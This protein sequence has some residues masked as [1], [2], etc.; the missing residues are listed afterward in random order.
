MAK[1]QQVCKRGAMAGCLWTVSCLSLDWPSRWTTKRIILH[2]SSPDMNYKGYLCSATCFF[3][4]FY[5]SLKSFFGALMPLVRYSVLLAA[6]LCG[7]PS[8]LSVCWQHRDFVYEMKW[9]VAS[10]LDPQITS[11]RQTTHS[12]F[13]LLGL[14]HLLSTSS[15][16]PQSALNPAGVTES[17]K[18]TA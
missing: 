4:T 11:E 15:G 16:H 10:L 14:L 12:A 18:K 9:E 17:N 2:S 13:L 3:Y 6:C 8:R 7:R 1:S 5:F